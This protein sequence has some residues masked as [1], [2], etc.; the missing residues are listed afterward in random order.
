MRK[1]I[2]LK[3]LR[4]QEYKYERRI[5]L[6]RPLYIVKRLK[7]RQ[8]NRNLQTPSQKPIKSHQNELKILPKTPS[9][10]L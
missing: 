1:N 10:L 5:E 8:P 4:D 6:L 7:N 9:N 2:L 3:T